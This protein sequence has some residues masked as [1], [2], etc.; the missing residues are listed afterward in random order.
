MKIKYIKI[1][2]HT[3]W[4]QEEIGKND[5]V[6]VLNGDYDTIINLDT[7]EYFVARDNKWEPIPRP[8][9]SQ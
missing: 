6:M 7:L 1:N 5:L 2:G 3:L 8:S 4:G 9:E